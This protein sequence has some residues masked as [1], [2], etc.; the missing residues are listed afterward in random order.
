MRIYGFNPSA[1]PLRA[2]LLSAGVNC[3]LFTNS[4]RILDSLS[5]FITTGPSSDRSLELEVF[6]D[7]TL[8]RV[9]D[10]PIYFRGLRHLVFA[11]L[12]PGE[13]FVFDLLR[14]RITGVVSAET[15]RDKS[16][17]ATRM[18]PLILGFMGITVGL[19]PLHCACLDLDGDGLLL[20]G[21]SLSGKSTLA[22]SLTRRGFALVSDGWTYLSKASG[23]ELTAHGIA[24]PVKL[25]PDAPQFFPELR[26]S[27]PARAFNGEIALEVD[28]REALNAAVHSESRPRWLVIL[29]RSQN[30]ASEIL[31]LSEEEVRDFLF[32]SVEILPPPLENLAEARSQLIMALSRIECWKMQYGGSP[33]AAA[34]M[35]HR[36]CK[37]SRFASVANCAVS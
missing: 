8:K 5:T 21:V 36:F 29:D 14:R 20:G 13:T 1:L 10:A 34:E 25:L 32:A 17:W 4:S 31:P 22:V 24:G 28:P 11:I 19:V 30:G 33:H 6:V 2:V 26:G 27:K 16:F 7:P 18:V 15:A 37:G 35:I 12:S 3:I 9:P 23:G